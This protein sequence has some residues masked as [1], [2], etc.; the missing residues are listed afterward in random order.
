MAF[1][2]ARSEHLDHASE[3]PA[4]VVA[5]GGDC[6]L[7]ITGIAKFQR[8]DV[9]GVIHR[10]TERDRLEAVGE[11]MADLRQ[12]YTHDED[13]LCGLPAM[14]NGISISIFRKRN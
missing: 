10:T 14:P 3:S 11:K 9:I 6:F 5:D 2:N 1:Y 12:W 4:L 8:S 7:K 13:M